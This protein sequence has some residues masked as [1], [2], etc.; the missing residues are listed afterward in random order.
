MSK[1]QK[2]QIHEYDPVIY[3]RKVWIIKGKGCGGDINEYFCDANYKPLIIDGFN[4]VYA[5]VW[6][7]VRYKPTDKLGV[8]IW[9]ISD[10]GVESCAHEA[11][12]AVNK[13]FTECDI[14]YAQEHDEH[15]AYFVGKIADWMYQ[16]WTGKFKD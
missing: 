3:P 15:F 4:G 12:H 16:V 8:L 6:G 5:C 9:L 13:I 2:L 14:D 11:V 1:T 7:I 10:V